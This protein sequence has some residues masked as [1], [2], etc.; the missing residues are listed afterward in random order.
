MAT[1]ATAAALSQPVLI[2]TVSQRGAVS[3]TFT[4]VVRV[5]YAQLPS[6]SS[7]WC[8]VAFGHVGRF[9]STGGV[10][11]FAQIGLRFLNG[12][13]IEPDTM[14]RVPLH[15]PLLADT[16]A[17]EYRNAGHPWCAVWNLNSG[18][19][20]NTSLA[21]SATI[22]QVSAPS[23]DPGSFWVDVSTIVVF[24]ISQLGIVYANNTTPSILP[25]SDVSHHPMVTTGTIPTAGDYVAFYS[26]QATPPRRNAAPDPLYP[27]NVWMTK[28]VSGV[29]D[30]SFGTVGFA[31][32]TGCVSRIPSEE[33]VI[34]PDPLYELYSLGGWYPVTAAADNTVD[35]QIRGWTNAA[36]STLARRPDSQY[37]AAFI[38]PRNAFTDVVLEAEDVIPGLLNR[39]PWTTAQT[40]V[41][42]IGDDRPAHYTI[43][44]TTLHDTV[45]DNDQTFTSLDVGGF[46]QQRF[47]TNAIQTR[48]VDPA[49][50]YLPNYASQL[51]TVAPFQAQWPELPVT[52]R[53]LINPWRTATADS[54]GSFALFSFTPTDAADRPPIVQRT[55]TYT[56]ISLTGT[57][58]DA[59][60]LLQLTTDEHPSESA[61]ISVET[62]VQSFTTDDGHVIRWPTWSKS[63][64]AWRVSWLC[65]QARYQILY[66]KLY[67]PDATLVI[68]MPSDWRDGANAVVKVD[69]LSAEQVGSNLVWRISATLIELVYTA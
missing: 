47:P 41:V 23:G 31:Q 32:V 33:W 45:E 10:D 58:I 16:A 20:T 11:K 3:P 14:T 35:I 62:G 21:I 22:E 1:Y 54:G 55:M 34:A 2:S 50:D 66:T 19:P 13:G 46:P 48:V 60:T 24:S 61:S 68:R 57:E 53:G 17:G 8:V 15:S 64:R 6:S 43:A 26:G 42:E 7:G 59:T 63:R 18:W 29:V 28:R 38:V 5:T 65:D 51:L 27:Y 25:Y 39:N 36:A 37:G 30:T 69:Q 9:R 49:L 4:D 56:A 44:M 40:H 67:R 12:S 52:T